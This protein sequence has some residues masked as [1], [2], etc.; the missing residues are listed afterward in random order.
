MTRTDHHEGS[1]Q[2]GRT[3]KL[4]TPARFEA[5]TLD[6]DYAKPESDRKR[7]PQ[8]KE[9]TMTNERRNT[10][11][12][13]ALQAIA[14]VWPV[15]E[16]CETIYWAA[17]K[18]DLINQAKIHRLIDEHNDSLEQ[19]KGGTLDLNAESAQLDEQLHQWTTEFENTAPLD[20]IQRFSA[21]Y[22]WVLKDSAARI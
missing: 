10:V 17:E 14:E 22:C 4:L 16:S 5:Q 3:A 19:G 13:L 12:L 11:G 15:E 2:D 6:P 20:Q 7:K 8:T 1:E 18:L 9:S 21:A